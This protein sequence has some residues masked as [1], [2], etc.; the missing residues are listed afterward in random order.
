MRCA[1]A[2]AAT[3]SRPPTAPA[4]RAPALT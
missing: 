3:A 4:K 1:R 2:A